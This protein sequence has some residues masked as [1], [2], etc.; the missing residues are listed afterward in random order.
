VLPAGPPIGP[1]TS[2]LNRKE[3]DEADMGV[4]VFEKT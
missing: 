3:A 1:P 2:P 4:V